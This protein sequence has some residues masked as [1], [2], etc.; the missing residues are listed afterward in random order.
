MFSLFLSP[1]VSAFLMLDAP[2]LYTFAINLLKCGYSRAVT[3]NY[4]RLREIH[5]D[6]LLLLGHNFL[7]ILSQE[8]LAFLGPVFSDGLYQAGEIF[9]RH[10]R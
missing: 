1:C 3:V 2:I 7:V 8:P 6:L 5:P 10:L 9:S 4:V